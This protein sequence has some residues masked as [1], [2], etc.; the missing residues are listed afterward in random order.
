MY[1]NLF[2]IGV[3]TTILVEIGLV[4][5]VAGIGHLRDKDEEEGR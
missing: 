4:F 1:I 5:L 2:W 3:L